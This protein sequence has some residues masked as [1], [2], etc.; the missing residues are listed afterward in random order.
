MDETLQ[1]CNSKAFSTMKEIIKNH[2][3]ND[4]DMYLFF[5]DKTT[6]TINTDT[7]TIDTG[8]AA[9][10]GGACDNVGY[11]KYSLTY[12][13]TRSVIATAEVSV[14]IHCNTCNR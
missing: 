2:N 4:V 9:G 6:R 12:G 8:K 10:I 5:T 11:R 7:I 13:P 3:D 1:C 14:N